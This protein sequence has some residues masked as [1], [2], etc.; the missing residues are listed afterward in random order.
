[1]K[2]AK[3]TGP[4]GTGVDLDVRLSDGQ[5][6]PVHVDQGHDLPGEIGGVSV[7]PA[8]WDNL[9]EQADWTEVKRDALPKS[10]DTTTAG[11]PGKE[12]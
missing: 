12:A 5:V 1:M 10:D 7:L 9:L 8:Y 2:K 3:Y 6:K 11:K 4:S